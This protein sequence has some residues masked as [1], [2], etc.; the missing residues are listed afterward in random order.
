MMLIT[1]EYVLFRAFPI[2]TNPEEEAVLKIKMGGNIFAMKRL[3]VY[4]WYSLT[5]SI[6]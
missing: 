6:S 5:Q 4:K 3:N 1:T 2:P